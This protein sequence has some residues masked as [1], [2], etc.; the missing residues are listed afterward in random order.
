MSDAVPS[1]ALERAIGS[2][3]AELR[4][5]LDQP[6]PHEAVERLRQA[7]RIWLVGTGTSQHA[8]ELGAS[9]L[10][11]AG[12]AAHA[13]SSMRFV[14]DPPPIDPRDAVI[15]ISH[16]AG[17]ETAYAWA[18]YTSA[19]AADLR[20][21]AITRRGGG[22]PEAVETVDRERS[23]TYTVSY[24]GALVLLA[25]LAAELGAEGFAPEMLSRIPDAVA[26]A[27]A[28]PGTDSIGQPARLLLLFGEGPASVT[29]REGALKAREASR[30][31]AEGYDVEYLLHGSAVP[32][33]PADHLIALSPP[34]T[35][36]L[37]EAVARAAEA[38]GIGV[39]RLSETA[40]LP[41]LLAQIPLVV[42]LQL[43]A[44]RFALERGHDPDLVIVGAWAGEDLW[45]I[46]SSKGPGPA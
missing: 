14:N 8:A 33:T 4:R 6:L 1:T 36:G 24:T 16:N 25:R 21:L 2:Q 41:P 45:A 37:T 19:V 46:G 26:G 9:M 5:L 40:D 18:A 7:H 27:L 32:L 35:D 39:T 29:A 34:D 13:I 15:V 31:P 42:R 22:L 44:L 17:A 20:V 11:R 30:F 3:A 10:H 28:E 12:R 23:H 38:E 43:L